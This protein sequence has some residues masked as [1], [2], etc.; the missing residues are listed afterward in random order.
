MSLLRD[1]Q[2]L[3]VIIILFS[4][5]PGLCKVRKDQQD[6][7]KIKITG[8]F[9]LRKVLFHPHFCFSF[10]FSLSPPTFPLALP[11]S[12]SLSLP[13]PRCP[14]FSHT[15]IPVSAHASLFLSL[16]LS[17]YMSGFFPL[18]LSRSLSIY[19][20]SPLSLMS[21]FFLFLFFSPLPICPLSAKQL[22]NERSH[23]SVSHPCYLCH[24]SG[25]ICT[26]LP[27][28]GTQSPKPAVRLIG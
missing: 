2:A 19:L 14:P 5:R 1:I 9:L 11:P 15:L 6:Q 18:S 23:E 26:P 3:N 21:F 7:E 25:T 20:S 28:L 8:S 4:H 10:S 16:S 27:I 22:L 13:L 24:G 17:L 12:H